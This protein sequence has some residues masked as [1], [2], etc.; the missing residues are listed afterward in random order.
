[1]FKILSGCG[2]ID[3]KWNG[4]CVRLLILKSGPLEEQTLLLV[5]RR[6]IEQGATIIVIGHDLDV[7][8]DAERQTGRYL[9]R[10]LAGGRSE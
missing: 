4:K 1:M 6:L 3:L 8:R 7:I 5:F 2:G 10:Y 9:K